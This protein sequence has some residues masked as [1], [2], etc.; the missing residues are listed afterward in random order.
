[1]PKRA[2]IIA[3]LLLL[4]LV[5]VA[6][7]FT[8]PPRTETFILRFVDSAT[9]QPV[10]NVQ[11]ALTEARNPRF[12]AL[13]E[14]L[15]L[16]NLD[17]WNPTTRELTASNAVLNVKVSTAS[18]FDTSL[19]CTAPKYL[20]SLVFFLDGQ[21]RGTHE[22]NVLVDPATW[23]RLAPTNGVLNIPMYSRPGN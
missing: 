7:L 17:L 16:F 15:L 2:A 14:V 20:A 3:A 21:W 5:A 19:D 23:P 8:R 10:Q 9:S 22:D 11:I 12:R 1:M 18:R 13:E 4:L 6:F